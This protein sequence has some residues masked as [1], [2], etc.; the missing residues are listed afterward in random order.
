[1][2]VNL[3]PWSSPQP[4]DMLGASGVSVDAVDNWGD[5]LRKCKKRERMILPRILSHFSG[6][7]AGLTGLDWGCA[8]GVVGFL[9]EN[10]LR[11]SEIVYADVCTKS[12]A[13]IK[14]QKPSGTICTLDPEPKLPWQDE[15]FDYIY[16]I[17]VL[18]HIAPALQVKYVEELHRI[19]KSG[20]LILLTL[21]GET[22]LEKEFRQKAPKRYARISDALASEGI[23][24]E[25]YNEERVRELP[26][27]E[28][29][30][31]GRTYHSRKYVRDNFE[32]KFD[33]SD[34]LPGELGGFQDLIVLRK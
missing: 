34:Y 29:Q 32:D 17:S 10:S 8:L 15:R 9:L 11:N 18:T 26:S 6:R 19:L 31:Y 33:T 30:S 14:K 21:A 20:G 3:L 13:Y 24:F 2:D 28:N 4:E 23:F 1:M 25:N 27:G 5:Y 7:A 22:A 12:L 16:G